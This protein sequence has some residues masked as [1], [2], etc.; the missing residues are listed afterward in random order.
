[1]REKPQTEQHLQGT[2]QMPQKYILSLN[3]F[4]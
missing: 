2:S 3:L 4:C 1:V